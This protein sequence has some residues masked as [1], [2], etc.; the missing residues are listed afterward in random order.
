[1]SYNSEEKRNDAIDFL[2]DSFQEVKEKRNLETGELE[3]VAEFNPKI[4]WFQAHN[5]NKPFGRYA[6]L[7]ERWE[8]LAVKC[9]SMMSPEPAAELAKDILL[10]L[11]E[12]KRGV[13]GKSSETYRDD[14]NTQASTFQILANKKQEKIYTVK[15]EAKKSLMDG[16]L[17]RE[18]REGVEE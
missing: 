11:N 9:Y 15:G 8:N 1:M 18:G 13:D 5:I 4:A 16:I 7:I 12:H 6:M 3:K 10:K 17:G 14:K 2:I